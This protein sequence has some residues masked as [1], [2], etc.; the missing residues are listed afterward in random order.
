MKI[1]DITIKINCENA[2]F[3]PAEE[4]EIA[5]ILRKLADR[6]ESGDEPCKLMDY[7]GNGV[8]TVDYE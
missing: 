4:Y 5:R 3:G 6:L 8:G 7:N 2:A 1:T